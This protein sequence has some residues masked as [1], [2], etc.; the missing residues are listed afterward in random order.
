MMGMSRHAGWIVTLAVLL[1]SHAAAAQGVGAG[2]L[3]ATLTDTEPT[4]AIFDL[5]RVKLA[6]G[7]TIDELGYDSNVFDEA[8]DP[9]D[10]YVVRAR[11]DIAVFSQLRWLTVSAYAGSSLAY[12]KTYDAENSAGYE[13]RGRVDFTVAR[14]YPFVGAGLTKHRTRPNG[15]I[16]TRADE[17]LE[18]VSGGLAFELGAHS[19]LYAAAAQYS[20][21]YEN[22]VEDGVDLG[23]ALSRVT[24]SYSGGVR[25]DVTPVT[26]LTISGGVAH[27]RFDESPDRDTTT[28]F[29][30]ASLNIGAE[31][32]LAGVVTVGY[33]YTEPVDPTVTPFRGMV[34]SVVLGYSFLEVMR[35]TGDVTRSLEYSF[36]AEDAYYLSTT[37]GLTFTYRLFGEVDAQVAGTKSWFDY[38][39][40]MD[41]PPRT[42]TLEAVN[43]SLGYNLRNRTRISLNYEEARR[44]SPAFLDRN[45]DRTRIYLAWKF[46]F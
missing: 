44:R 7:L 6:P 19:V 34:G 21:D 18:E 1:Y 10:D 12:F 36:D 4:S 16:D 14:L 28:N 20:T 26:S 45:Y 46:A 25:T 32:A 24:S 40:A 41:V 31:A 42:D 27:D 38:E 2:P 35:L 17:E 37:A 33:N 29:V 23:A 3:T 9:K 13:F 39:H 30:S 5:G 8:V 15:E 22:S 11:P 43:V